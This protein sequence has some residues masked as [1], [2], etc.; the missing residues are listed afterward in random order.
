MGTPSLS[1]AVKAHKLYCTKGSIAQEYSPE[2]TTEI[3]PLLLFSPKDET[4]FSRC[5]YIILFDFFKAD[6]R[7]AWV[8][9]EMYPLCPFYFSSHCHPYPKGAFSVFEESIQ[10]GL[11]C[12]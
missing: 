2:D 11:F 3:K 7:L 4:A 9:S 6:S 1:Q 8:F 12:S 5:F 10:F